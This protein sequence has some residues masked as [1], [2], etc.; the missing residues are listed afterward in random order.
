M[1]FEITLSGKVALITGGARGIGSEICRQLARAEADIVINRH[2]LEID[3]IACEEL[4]KELSSYGKRV[5]SIE[6][7]VSVESEVNAMVTKVIK[8]FNQ[9]DILVNNAGILIPSRIEEM[10]YEEWKRVI[11]VN[12]YGTF[13]VTRSVIP[14]MYKNNSGSIIMVTSGTTINGGG[15]SV[16][17]PASKAGME[18]MMKQ[19]VRESSAYGVRVNVIQPAVIDTDLLRERYS[20]D[21]EVEKYGKSIPIGRVG[22]AE[23]I[24]NAIVFLVSDK[25]SYITGASL[26]IDG[27]RTYYKN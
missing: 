18:G 1:A 22:K 26:L 6:A 19:L 21:E 16:A 10:T 24:A 8:E 5:M 27:G 23:D 7:D 9:I 3:R 17:Y 2:H 11:E 13:L 15:G 20:T 4:E 25:A 14:Y 12:L